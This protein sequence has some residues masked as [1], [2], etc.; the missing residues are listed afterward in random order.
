MY[1]SCPG[2]RAGLVSISSAPL[3]SGDTVSQLALITNHA[4]S[5]TTTYFPIPTLRELT[6]TIP[7]TPTTHSS[8]AQSQEGP[9]EEPMATVTAAVPDLS[10]DTLTSWLQ[11]EHKTLLDLLRAAWGVTLVSYT[12]SEDVW[13]RSYS[14]SGGNRYGIPPQASFLSEPVSEFGRLMERIK[15]VALSRL[16]DATR[17]FAL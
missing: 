6:R 5:M 17:A 13:F 15:L 10:G 8:P 11:A 4:R 16:V 9:C 12:G 14:Q 3:I 2:A 1:G 7:P